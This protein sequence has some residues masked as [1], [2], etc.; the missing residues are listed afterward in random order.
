LSNVLAA[1]C[2]FCLVGFQLRL[3]V[4]TLVDGL[5]SDF[6]KTFDT[7]IKVVVVLQ[8]FV[9]HT[10]PSAVAVMPPGHPL[11]LSVF[12]VGIQTPELWRVAILVGVFRRV[13]RSAIT[14]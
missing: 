2:N 4:D 12:I 1:H 11:T 3:S 9:M 5:S 10:A 13:V 6:F 7:S 8:R 14:H